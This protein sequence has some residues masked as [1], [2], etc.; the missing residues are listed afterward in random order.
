MLEAA[1]ETAST[2]FELD[3]S[4]NTIRFERELSGSADSVFSAWTD[5]RQVESWWDPEGRPLDKCEIDL[6][7]GGQFSFLSQGHSDRPFTG[8]YVEIARPNLL[9]FEAM[10]AQGRVQLREDKGQ[11]QM[12]VEIIC[13]S[14]EHLEQFVQMGAAP[15][16][17]KTLD[18]LV[19]YIQSSGR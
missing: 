6:K 16:T 1:S 15:G 7:V 19:D 18:N 11:T 9:V 14:E 17:S 8:T 3:R 12:T 2:G 4:S 5:P 10:G 13:S